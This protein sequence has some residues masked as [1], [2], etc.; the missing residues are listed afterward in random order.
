ME[1]MPADLYKYVCFEENFLYLN[2]KNA[3][4][5]KVSEIIWKLIQNDKKPRTSSEIS[6]V[7]LK[8][9]FNTFTLMS[10]LRCIVQLKEEVSI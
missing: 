7:S 10:I 3:L 8:T 6:C 9:F 5:P 1:N 2:G 4:Y